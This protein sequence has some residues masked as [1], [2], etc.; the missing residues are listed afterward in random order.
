M[1][2]GV[3]VG[4]L[5]L[6]SGL[7]NMIVLNGPAN[8]LAFTFPNVAFSLV[9]GLVLLS[10][11]LYGRAS[12]QLPADNPFRQAHGDRNRMAR[13]W[14]GEDF[15]QTEDLGEEPASVRRVLGQDLAEH[16]VVNDSCFAH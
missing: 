8:V 4:G 9:V 16:G 3:V 7:V 10:V 14:H 1:N 13:F 12:G 5:F 11:G 6:V 2:V 15:A